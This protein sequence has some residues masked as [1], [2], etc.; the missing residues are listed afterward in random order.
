M[1][2]DFFST[3]KKIKPLG[4]GGMGSTSLYKNKKTGKLFAVKEIF[5]DVPMSFLE[6]EFNVLQKIFKD[7]KTRNVLCLHEK[8]VKDGKTY[9][10]TEYLKGMSFY[11]YMEKLTKPDINK[12]SKYVQDVAKGLSYIHNRNI[13]H[14]DIKPENIMITKNHA[15]IIDF[16]IAVVGNKNTIY[17]HGGGTPEY[18]PSYFL[19]KGIIPIQTAKSYDIYALGMTLIELLNTLEFD[20]DES[21]GFTE[22]IEL[23]VK[24]APLSKKEYESVMKFLKTFKIPPYMRK[25]W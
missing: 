7:C 8:I 4:A 5:D 21:P 10:V 12:I 15:K 11:K 17:H 2:K 6:G 13:V 22:M 16:G 20:W 24:D 9:F 25:V 1:P 14:L 18:T 23:M 3:H 19:G